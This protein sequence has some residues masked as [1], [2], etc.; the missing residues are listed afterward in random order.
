MKEAFL[1]SAVQV[2]KSEQFP[3]KNSIAIV[4]DKPSYLP[5]Q[6]VQGQV[7][8][9]LKSQTDINSLAVYLQ[10]VE[11]T[12]IFIYSKQG[13]NFDSSRLMA[14]AGLWLSQKATIPAGSTAFPFFFDLPPDALPS[15]MGKHAN[16][17]WN[18]TAKASIGWRR[19][20]EQGVSLVVANGSTL[21]PVSPTLES[22]EAVP[23]IRLSLSSNI[24]QP[25]ETIE[26]KITLLVAG[27]ARGVRLQ[28]SMD[29][30]SEAHGKD[31]NQ[32]A[33]E[34][35]AVG[36]PLAFS[37]ESLAGSLE[38]P[39]QIPLL[40]QSPCSYNGAF[41]SIAWYIYAT[42]DVPHGRDV[43]LRLP[44]TV[45]MRTAQPVTIQPALAA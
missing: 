15:Y 37:P 8:L 10:G 21:P 7:R 29:E 2:P 30:Q 13:G 22:V 20:L 4:W 16:V 44:F 34:T 1:E 32:S 45:G 9:N 12:H 23:R 17:T 25:G 39:F 19:D 42:V 3:D 33:T 11:K 43:H 35:V 5:G 31:H 26:G 14:N 27:N 24:Y 18:L 38:V 28:L 6:R 41:S 40:P 36:N